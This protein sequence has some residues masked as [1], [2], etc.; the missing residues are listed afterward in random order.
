M[1]NAKE[2]KNRQLHKHFEEQIR[3]IDQQQRNTVNNEPTEKEG[4]ER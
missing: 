2:G 3:R 1:N 4:S